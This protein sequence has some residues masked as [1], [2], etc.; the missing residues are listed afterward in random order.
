MT[1]ERKEELKPCPFC[2]G[3]AKMIPWHGRMASCSNE[4]CPVEP[5]VWGETPAKAAA[6]WN[7][8]DPAVAAEAREE[9]IDE[10]CELE[11]VEIAEIISDWYEWG[12]AIKAIKKLA[13]R[14][15]EKR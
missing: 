2:G 8:R 5:S 9:G 6:F 14:L 11:E 13:E 12:D 4:E 3:K 1:E 15:K 10:L 7:R